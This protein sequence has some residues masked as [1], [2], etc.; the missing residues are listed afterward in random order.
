MNIIGYTVSY[1]FS[2]MIQFTRTWTGTVA[3][4]F[5]TMQLEETPPLA[6]CTRWDVLCDVHCTLYLVQGGEDLQPFF[7]PQSCLL[8]CYQ[9]IQEITQG[10]RSLQQLPR[11]HN[12]WRDLYCP[13][14]GIF[15]KHSN[16]VFCNNQYARKWNNS[17]RK[18]YHLAKHPQ[19]RSMTLWHH[20][21]WSPPLLLHTCL[22]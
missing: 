22:Q 12:M 6:R 3:W 13:L 18:L 10:G 5:A 16:N 9:R 19:R 1:I 15:L 21:Q 11:K 17:K 8:W 20:D 4:L 2:T 14:R 7:G